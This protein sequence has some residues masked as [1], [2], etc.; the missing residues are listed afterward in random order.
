[1]NKILIINLK[2]HGDIYQMNHLVNGILANS[3]NTEV[4][5][6]VYEEFKKSAKTLKGISN[7]YTINKK[8]IESFFKNEI[9]STAFALDELFSSMEKVSHEKWSNV[10]NYSNDRASTFLTSYLCSLSHTKHTGIKFRSNKTI[11]F[12]NQWAVV[13]NDVATSCF[14]SPISFSNIYA[15][16]LNVPVTNAIDSIKTNSQHNNS[17]SINFEK[18]RKI[19]SENVENVT[20]CGIQLKTSN[21]EKDIGK[22]NIIEF[23]RYANSTDFLLPTLLVSPSKEEKDLANE[24]NSHFDNTLVSIESD[25]IALPS[26]LLNLDILITPDTLTKHLADVLSTPCVEVA[27]G[28]APIF[29]QGTNNMQ[30]I[31]VRSEQDPTLYTT[32]TKVLGKDIF[33][34]ALLVLDKLDQ[35]ELELSEN[36]QIYVNQMDKTGTFLV[37]VLRTD[38]SENEAQRIFERKILLKLLEHKSESIHDHLVT[39]LCSTKFYKWAENEKI[40]ISYV[41]KDLLTCLRFLIQTQENIQK[42]NSF[43]SSLDKLLAHVNSS[44]SARIPLLLFRAKVENIEQVDLKNNLKVVEKYLYEL[45][46]DLQ[47]C[48]HGLKEVEHFA[49]ENRSKESIRSVRKEGVLNG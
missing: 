7:I 22:E 10:I 8:K 25:L 1:M 27:N 36:T 21:I 2:R 11:D 15:K 32:S 42:A 33:Q 20:V 41:T 46:N 40:S 26:V 19:K 34:A 13:L 4:S 30:S 29:K 5:I 48:L 12:S 43:I 37:P 31:V 44:S 24:I 18:L 3:L 23:I 17:A 6:L 39:H 35:S 47:I 16:M 14:N 45:K 9:Y 49:T 38:F 28:I